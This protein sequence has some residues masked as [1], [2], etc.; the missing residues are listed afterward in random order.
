MNNKKKTKYSNYI[1]KLNIKI[2]KKLNKHNIT[3]DDLHDL[4]HYYDLLMC[5]DYYDN[6]D[7]YKGKLEEYR[8]ELGDKIDL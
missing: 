2:D 1:K 7:H 6:Y 8:R 4:F 3:N 5:F